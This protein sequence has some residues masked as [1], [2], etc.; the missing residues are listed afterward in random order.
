MNF[1]LHAIARSLETETCATHNMQPKAEVV[2][3]D[4]RISACCEPFNIELQEKL[5][6]GIAKQLEASLEEML[7]GF[8][9][10]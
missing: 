3:G 2:D 6:A 1:D 10:E 4:V 8:G 7:K 5:Q 9:P